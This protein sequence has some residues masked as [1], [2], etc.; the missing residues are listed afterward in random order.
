M[1]NNQQLHPSARKFSTLLVST[2]FVCAFSTFSSAEK[3]EHISQGELN[4]LAP[5]VAFE[6]A[7]EV[8]D[9]LFEHS[10]TAAEGVGANVGFGIRFTLVP[11][12]DLDNEQQWAQHLPKRVTGPNAQ[13]CDACHS[14][15]FGDGAGKVMMN[16]IRDPLHS[17]DP[18]KF[19]SRQ[20]PHIFG[21]GALQLLAEEMSDALQRQLQQAKTQAAAS[22][23]TVQLALRA[24]QIEFGTLSVAADG[25]IDTRQLQGIGTDLLIKP[26]EWKGITS[27]IRAFVRDAGHNELGMQSTEIVGDDV[28]GDGDGVVN[29]LSVGDITAIVIYQA[30]QPR[31]T[32]VQ[33]LAS[34][35]L[36]EPLNA[37]QQ[38]QINSG[39]T[40]FSN[41]GCSSCHTPQL[42]IDNPIYSEPSRSQSYRD[43]LFPAGQDP[44][45]QGLSLQQAI[46][47]DLTKDLP[48]NIIEHADGSKTHLGN[49]QTNQSGQAIVR[50]FA[51]LKRHDMG[52]DLAEPIDEAGTGAA[53]FITKE[54]WGVGS[55]APYLHDGRATTLDEAILWHGGEALAAKQQYQGLPQADK[56]ALLAFLNNLVLYKAEEPE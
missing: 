7:F 36:A 25:S 18:S 33:E 20:P 14:L 44:I 23:K 53:N 27:N 4:K 54:L 9:E 49:F 8:G 11:R 3:A 17:A 1:K 55:T 48:D 40:L 10:F 56:Q 19:I 22:G 12:A 2:L 15:P 47:F 6:T 35:G 46:T 38:Q 32:T 39:E 28:D 51:D 30:A 5:K 29:E 42:L 50:L 52:Q 31:P 24:K 41:S 26:I 43:Q 37:E 21:L 16:N 45:E 34:L 13:S